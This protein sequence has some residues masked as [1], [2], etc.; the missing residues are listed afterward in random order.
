MD[1]EIKLCKDC[2]FLRDEKCMHEKAIREPDYVHGNAPEQYSAKTIRLTES[3]CGKDA[4]WFERKCGID[5]P[6]WS[7]EKI[8]E[9]DQH[10]ESRDYGAES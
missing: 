2:R 5:D 3:D 4:K 7:A 10:E 8:Q 9:F 1:A 6:T